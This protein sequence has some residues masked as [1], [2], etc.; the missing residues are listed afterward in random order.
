MYLDGRGLRHRGRRG[1]VIIDDSYLLLLHSGDG[2]C[3]FT[4]PGAPWA[5]AYEVVVDT[6][7]VAGIPRTLDL[8]AGG[9]CYDLIARSVM[10][11]KIHR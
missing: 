4:L 1:E 6:A 3:A 2:P 10:L 5:A 9:K 11:F 7:Q 8:I